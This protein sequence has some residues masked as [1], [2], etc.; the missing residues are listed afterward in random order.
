MSDSS[1]P[2]EPTNPTSRR[3]HQS[4]SN[5][6]D[7]FGLVMRM[8]R[9]GSPAARAALWHAALGLAATPVDWALERSEKRRL[10]GAS[11]SS[12]PLLLIIG[13]PR[14]GTTLAYQVLARYLDVTYFTNLS[15]LFPRAPLTA[16]RMF[17]RH[18]AAAADFHS[19]YGQTS[20]LA[21]PNDG[22]HV[23]N[24][25][26]GHDRYRTPQQLG[27]A[28]RAEMIR[29]VG[30]WCTEFD[31]PLLNKNNRNTDC[32]ALLAEIF[33]NAYFLDLRREPLHVVQ[34]LVTA[35]QRIQGSKT[36]GWGLQSRD[37]A[38]S[39][40]P[41][42]YVD[43]VCDQVTGILS[44]LQE[45]KQRVGPH[46]FMDIRYEDLAQDPQRVVRQIAEWIPN[47]RLHEDLLDSELT[48]FHPSSGPQL[49][50]AELERAR[51]RLGEG[52]T[53]SSA[54]ECQCVNAHSG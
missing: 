17:G 35:R 49:E 39:P 37:E 54:Q 9:S 53:A 20:G 12:L 1:P 48:P 10:A 29:F 24:R 34:S 47:L 28:E 25:W 19:F 23:W 36:A 4:Y 44:K 52:Q 26:L 18:Q 46:R 3:P 13:A 7:P 16:S 22:F 33:E 8:I 14:S 41:L 21:A 11:P 31:K 51:A 2:T 50:P 38:S 40:D 6:R 27:A 45:D 42:S 32:V 15:A 43:D 5:F 30:A